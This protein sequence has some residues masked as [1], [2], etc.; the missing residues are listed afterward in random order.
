MT[1]RKPTRGLARGLAILC[2][3]LIGILVA[4]P[5]AALERGLARDAKR[6]DAAVVQV[7][8]QAAHALRRLDRGVVELPVDDDG[9]DAWRAWATPVAAGP[10]WVVPAWLDPP[11]G[12]DRDLVLRIDPG[13]AFGS[14]SHPTT[15]LVLQ[16]LAE[17]VG[18]GDRVLDVG[19]GTGALL[20]RYLAGG[21][22]AV[23]IDASPA[24][25]AE[26][27]PGITMDQRREMGERCAEACRKINYRGAGTFEF[28]FQDGEFYFIEMNT[29]VQVEHTIT[30]TITGVDI[31]EEQIRV[32]A[33]LPLR[34]KQHEITRRGFAMQFR[35]N[36]E[37]PKNNFLLSFGRIM[38]RVL[39]IGRFVAFYLVA[40]LVSSAS[41][42]LLSLVVLDKTRKWG[43]PWID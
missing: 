20:E 26:P 40:A 27:A 33:G 35:I 31:V 28:L 15:R 21:G 30:E 5:A 9:L 17:R 19:C 42:C 18:P 10:W 32:A 7:R 11:D 3:P 22:Q 12:A 41:H 38:E 36:A 29:R 1:R 6:R 39:G 23:G 8:R 43:R 4:G 13:R 24:M 14:G 2:L 25:L 37:D 16:V 34:F